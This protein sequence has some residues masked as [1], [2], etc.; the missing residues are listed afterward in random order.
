MARARR[1]TTRYYYRNDAIKKVDTLYLAAILLL[2]RRSAH[3][4]WLIHSI[5]IH[6]VASV[7]PDFWFDEPSIRIAVEY[8][9]CSM[10]CRYEM[11]CTSNGFCFLSLVFYIVVS[12]NDNT[13]YVLSLVYIE[14]LWKAMSWEADLAISSPTLMVGASPITLFPNT[15]MWA[16]DGIRREIEG[17]AEEETLVAIHPY[18]WHACGCLFAN[19]TDAST[20]PGLQLG[21]V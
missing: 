1:H 7:Y 12:W 9:L 11:F 6:N 14:A 17:A 18:H 4:L 13:S 10:L 19:S 16:L 3:A 5:T 8:R 20:R 21:C 2:R 15:R